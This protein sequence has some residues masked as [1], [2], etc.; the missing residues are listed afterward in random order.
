MTPAGAPLEAPALLRIKDLRVSYRR[1]RRP[2]RVVDGVSL[3]VDRGET[4]AVVGESGAGKT[5]LA[6]AVVGLAPVE[7]GTIELCGQDV[8]RATPRQRRGLAR[9]AQYIFQDPYSSLNPARTI[10]QTLEE[11]LLARGVRGAKAARR[12]EEILDLVGIPGSA[13]SRYP[14]A[15]SG[16]QRQ[17]I[18]IAR[19]LLPAPDLVICDEPVSA[20]DLSVQAQILNL[21]RTLQ[22]RFGIGYLFIG[23]NLDVVRVVAHRTIVMRHGQV[24]EEGPSDVVAREPRHPYTQA[25]LAATLPAD[26]AQRRARRALAPTL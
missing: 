1:H 3:S 13:R 4:V 7:S 11:P 23:H 16:G 2:V 24:V 8:T 9:R 19:A 17:R 12:I 25:L 15:F 18:A 21:L 5:S 20:L 6:R 10:G 14:A 26:P 22:Q